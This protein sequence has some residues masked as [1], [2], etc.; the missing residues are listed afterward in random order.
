MEIPSHALR[1]FHRPDWERIPLGTRVFACDGDETTGL[2]KQAELELWDDE[3]FKKAQVV[4]I[5]DGKKALVDIGMLALSEH[6]E[7]SDDGSSDSSSDGEEEEDEEE[8]QTEGIGILVPGGIQTDT[9]TFA[10]WEKH[11]RGVASKMMASMGYRVGMGL[12][13]SG[14]G[15][16]APIE[17][18]VL[19]PKQSLDFINEKRHK[20]RDKEGTKGHEGKKKTRG[21]KRSRYKKWAAAALAAKTDR[22]KAPD[23]FGI[24]NQHLGPVR[25]DETSFGS[26]SQRFEPK[27]SR[28]PIGQKKMQRKEDRRSIVAH[29]DSIMEIRGKITK[30][31]EMA[32]RNRKEKAVYDGV[33][34]KLEVARR[35]LS[36]AE[37]AHASATNA[38]HSK[39]K[40]KKWLRF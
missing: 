4:F 2:W 30:L 20:E 33:N 1:L 15:Q 35:A 10:N 29:E 24:I 37:A 28:E 22:D 16:I 25:H 6:A 40:E 23:V 32:L 12:G 7:L 5:G 18:R 9:T 39:E 11:T 19:P 17:A 31:E 26:G 36:E 27:E 38:V 3:F 34:R 21:G 8:E 13:I 14:Q